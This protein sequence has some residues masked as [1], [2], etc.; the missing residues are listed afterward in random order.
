[1]NRDIKLIRPKSKVDVNELLEE[2]LEI[3]SLNQKNLLVRVQNGMPLDG[4]QVRAVQ[5]TIRSIALLR[6]VKLKEIELDKKLEELE[7]EKTKQLSDDELIEKIKKLA[8]SVEGKNA[9]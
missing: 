4:F 6:D 2:A 8:D 9:K 7:N 3:L 1:M 5:D